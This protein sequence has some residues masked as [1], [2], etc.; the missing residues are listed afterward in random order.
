MSDRPRSKRLVDILTFSLTAALVAAP[1]ILYY[2]QNPQALSYRT[3]TLL[4]FDAGNPLPTFTH[5]LISLAQIQFG[6]GTWLGQ[7]P[8]LNVFTGLGLLAGLLVCLYHFQKPACMFLMIWW[9]VGLGPVLISQQDWTGTTTLLRGIVAWPAIYLIAAIGLASL[10]RTAYHFIKKSSVFPQPAAEI[11]LLG[12]VFLFGVFTTANNYYSTWAGTYNDFSDHPPYI[13]RYLNSQTDQL[14]LTPLKFYGETAGNFLLQEHYPRLTNIGPQKLRDLLSSGQPAVYLIPADS[15]GE[16]TFV[17]LNPAT[18]TAYLLPPLTPSQVKLLVEHSQNT[19]PLNTV[20]D[21]EQEPIARVYPLSADMPFLPNRTETPGR[22]IHAEFAETILLVNYQ[23]TPPTLNP[24]DAVTLSLNWQARRPFDDEYILF[25]HLFDITTG[26]RWGQ[27][28]VP[29]TGILFDARR[30]PVGLTVPDRH[31]FLFPADAPDGP[32]H[33]ELGLYRA[34]SQER[35]PVIADSTHSPD[36]KIIFGKL[37]VGQPPGQPQIQLE[38]IQFE[39]NLALQG[40]DIKTTSLPPGQPLAYQLHW[41]ALDF[42]AKDYVVFNHL[43]DS[44]GHIQAQQDNQPLQGR[45]PTSWW[46]PGE[47]VVDPYTLTLP[48]DLPAGTYTLRVG[49]YEAQTGQRLPRKNQAQDFV[50]FPNLITVE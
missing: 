16:S 10:L 47:I 37:Y 44:Q 42:I 41:Q 12:L 5:N 9:V 24:G 29:L 28:N 20:L 50:D 8:A 6:V 43:L 31:T 40:V 38:N 30:W 7:W 21:S 2:V 19:V 36:D 22:P 39:D 13:A 27:I 26:Q 34:G 45:Y 35:L 48:P 15:D 14:T 49:L 17:L 32:Y 23:I 11:S 33:F 18:N 46:N 25:I 1:L 3:Q 4:I